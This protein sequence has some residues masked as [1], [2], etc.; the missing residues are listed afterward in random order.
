MQRRFGRMDRDASCEDFGAIIGEVDITG[1]V[2]ES[3]SVWFAGPYGFTLANPVLYEKPIPCRGALG[4]F[5]P[6]IKE[7]PDDPL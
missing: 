5:T 6:D 4:F 3:T 2:T 7:L 1:C